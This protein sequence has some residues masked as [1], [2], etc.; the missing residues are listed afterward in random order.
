MKRAQFSSSPSDQAPQGKQYS[1]SGEADNPHRSSC[2]SEKF[3]ESHRR[4]SRPGGALRKGACPRQ[5]GTAFAAEEEEEDHWYV[6]VKGYLTTITHHICS[7]SFHSRALEKRLLGQR[8]RYEPA[9]HLSTHTCPA[10]PLAITSVNANDVHDV[11]SASVAHS[12][13][14]FIS[15]VH[16]HVRSS[17]SYGY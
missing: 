13:A 16:F 6:P 17:A 1:S 4:S 12:A 14:M 2:D 3:K 8:I 5:Q 9:S 11:Q 7:F 10:V 15:A